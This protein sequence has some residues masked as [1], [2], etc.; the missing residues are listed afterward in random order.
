[1]SVKQPEL[2]PEF[3]ALLNYLKRARS[4]DFTGYKRSSLQRRIQR[5]MQTINVESYSDYIDYLEVHPDEFGRMFD[6]ILINVTN[7]FRDPGAWE[8][9]ESEIIP[10]I[11]ASKKNDESIRIWSAGCAS[12]EE[13]YTIAMYMAE[14]VGPERFRERVKIYAS[15]LDEQALSQG[16]Q[17]TYTA[18]E[19][20]NI[21]NAML[22]KY[23]ERT[24][25]RFT[26]R[27]DLRRAVIFGRHDLV[28]DAPISRIDLLI[29]RNVLMYFNAETQSKILSRFHFAVSDTGFLFLG[30]AEM[31]FTH[32]SLFQPV[33]LRR[34]VFKKVP[35]VTL[36]DRLLI[37]T[38]AGDEEAATHL[39]RHVRFREVSFDAGP[40]AQVVTDLNGYLVLANERTRTL[41][42]INLKDLGRPMPEY[43]M[44]FRIPELRS[45]LEEIHS[46]RRPVLLKEID[47]STSSGDIRTLEIQMSPLFDNGS[48]YLGVSI[49]FTDV[50]RYRRLQ[51]EIEHSN[52]E[53]ETAYE[54]LQSTNE[55]LETTNEELQST[56]EELETTNEELQS[57]NEELET[58][59]EEL[60]S[61]NE[62][63]QTM[64]EELR[65]RTDELNYVNGFLESIL[66]SMRGAV[67]VV[68]RDLRVQ[69]WS[70][71]AEDLW[72]LRASE[73]ENKN[74]L[75]LDFGL[76]VDQLKGTIRASLAQEQDYFTVMLNATNRRGKAIQI[77]VTCSPLLNSSN[78][79]VRGVILLM[80]EQDGSAP[81]ASQAQASG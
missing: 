31:L 30:K 3:E 27:K 65:R 16:R 70:P 50:T 20:A 43:E 17:A 4:F 21:P 46:E 32:A 49:T 56:V 81:A 41:L 59:N 76:P 60:Q 39:S 54:E 6:T 80:E 38:Q 8:Y 25:Q 36:R 34:R 79:A 52:Q 61:A 72:G 2:N 78:E 37:M 1:M 26:F 62:E 35:R 24:D 55:E 7:F 5:R 53:L 45:K 15:D 9:L 68:D 42:G 22:E 29:C 66:T 13:A 28:Q 67:V 75:Y 58:M 10:Q 47:W 48:S 23:F 11:I 69:V 18:R 14:A 19:V 51:E 74:F 40:V 63:L 77:E 12:G 73:V 64:N 57:T 44:V 33:D 71:K